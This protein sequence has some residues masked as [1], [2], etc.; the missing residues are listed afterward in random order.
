M[1]SE[2]IQGRKFSDKIQDRK[3]NPERPSHALITLT[4]RGNTDDGKDECQV[5]EKKLLRAYFDSR[6]KKLWFYVHFI[7]TLIPL[8]AQAVAR[9]LLECCFFYAQILLYGTE[10]AA[11]PQ[12]WLKNNFRVNMLY[13]CEESPCPLPTQCWVSRPMEKTIFLR[14]MTSMNAFSILLSMVEIL[15]LMS[16]RV[17]KIILKHRIKK[18]QNAQSYHDDLR[19]SS[20]R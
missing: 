20:H 13:I 8:P 15:Q 12:K 11:L 6:I 10:Y 14:F 5:R 2:K 7:H 4:S 1:G 18:L 19:Y 17:R 9:L 16:R 3:L